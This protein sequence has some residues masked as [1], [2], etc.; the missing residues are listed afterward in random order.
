MFLLHGL[1]IALGDGI[2]SM[3]HKSYFL[4][5]FPPFFYF[6]KLSFFPIML[7]FCDFLLYFIIIIIIFLWMDFVIKKILDQEIKF[8]IQKRK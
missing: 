7:I 2:L 3:H 4:S 8:L 1:I 5:Y 6:F